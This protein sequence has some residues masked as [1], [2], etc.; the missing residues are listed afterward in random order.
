M[1][2]PEGKRLT[3]AYFI[4]EPKKDDTFEA[5]PQHWTIFP[6][7]WA[8]V[9]SGGVV[10]NRAT[11]GLYQFPITLDSE[12]GSEGR[13]IRLFDEMSTLKARQ[14]HLRVMKALL[15][16]HIDVSQLNHIGV[17]YRHPHITQRPYHAQLEAG[18]SLI[19]DHLA[20]VVRETEGPGV[21]RVHRVAQFKS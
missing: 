4:E 10:L 14:L 17:D 19:I 1:S 5:W 11:E 13:R 21:S 7:V 3:F 20:M 6:P 8:P 12:E 9:F 18:Q 16:L 15:S 2:S